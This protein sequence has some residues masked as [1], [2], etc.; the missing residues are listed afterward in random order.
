MLVHGL[1]WVQS[2]QE[3]I[4]FYKSL[5]SFPFIVLTR[6]LGW[7]KYN[8]Q[9]NYTPTGMLR[10]TLSDWKPVEYHITI[11]YHVL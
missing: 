3:T 2:L 4:I 1:D 10:I 9:A 5:I 11:T 7:L 6:T 8:G